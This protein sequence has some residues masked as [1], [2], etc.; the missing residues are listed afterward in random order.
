M[1]AI[2]IGNKL[3]PV[4]IVKEAQTALNVLLVN[5]PDLVRREVDVDLLELLI[6]SL[7]FIH[8]N[9]WLNFS[10]IF[11]ACDAFE[12]QIFQRLRLQLFQAV[13]TSLNHHILSSSDNRELVNDVKLCAFA[14]RTIGNLI[15]EDVHTMNEWKRF[16]ALEPTL[17][18]RI[19]ELDDVLTKDVLWVVAET[20][21]EHFGSLKVHNSVRSGVFM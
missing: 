13:V 3:I 12:Y 4:E 16:L 19:L 8:S 10:I 18:Q 20:G 15:V 7:S 17:M 14:L 11:Y 9:Y 5:H 1:L 21:Y 2:I 6:K